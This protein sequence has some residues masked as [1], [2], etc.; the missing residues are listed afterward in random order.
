MPQENTSAGVSVR[1]IDLTGPT[2]IEPVGIPAGIIGT[3]A[4]G[5]AFVPMTLPTMPDFI[6]KFG[7]PTSIY[8]N[9]PLAANEWLRNAQA[10]TFLRVLG[11]GD[12]TQRTASGDN[13]GKVT[14]AGFVVGDEQPQASVS[15]ALSSNPYAVTTGAPGKT[16]FLGTF[17][18]QSTNSSVL[19]DAGL[20]AAGQPILRAVLMA[21]SG[22]VLALSSAT[23]NSSQP[24]TGSSSAI[25]RGTPSGS[26][27]VANSLQE[28]V[29]LL[30]G[31]N[32]AD[33][34]Y[35]NVITASF[36][37]TA[38]NYF[39]KVFN[40]DP[41]KVE[42]AGYVLYT[43]YDIHPSLAVVT[44]ALALTPSA[45][46]ITSDPVVPF[47]LEK[48]AF[49]VTNEQTWNSG[50]LYTPNFENF[51]DRFQ[52]AKTPWITSQKFGGNPQN[53]FQIVAL[54]DGEVPNTE[55]KISFENIQPSNSDVTNFGTF[56]L[57]VRDLNDNDNNKIV[58]EQWRGLS[59]DVDSPKF[60]G[61]VIGDTR[62]FFN[63]DATVGKQ[64]LTTVGNYPVKSRFIRLNL[65]DNLLNGETPETALPMGCRGFPHLMTSGSE[66]LATLVDATT[67]TV[68][69]TNRL[70][71]PPVPFRLNLTKGTSPNLSTDKALY[72]GVQFERQ[73]SAT[74][75]NNSY[76]PNDTIKSF[77]K[78]FANYHTDWLN[79]I[80]SSNEGAADTT[81]N[82]I[83][84]ADRFNFNAF[85]LENIR[86]VYNSTSGIADV[87]SLDSWAYVRS[88]SISTNS[89][90]LTRAL[91]VSD[92]LDPS[93]RA[94]AKFSVF[95]QGGFN[96]TRMFNAE[97]SQMTNNAIV[98]EMNNSDRGF[99]S[100]PTVSAYIKA[101]SVMEDTSEVDVQLLAIP[102]IRHRYV[103]DTAIRSTENRFDALYLF[104]IEERDTNNNLVTSD[105]Q[106]ISIDYTATDFSNRG[107]NSSF[108]A[109][110]F[111]DLMLQTQ[112]LRSFARTPPTVSVLGAFSLND[113]IGYPW[114]APAGFARGA[115]ASTTEPVV[116]LSKDNM[117]DLYSVRINPIVSFPGSTGP[118]VWGQKT[119]LARQSS[120]DRVNV[121]RLLISLRREVRSVA[122]RILFE[123]NREA[124]LTRFSQQVNPI[125]KKVQ[126]KRGIDNY[127]IVI[128]TSTTT[129]ADIENKTIRGKI[130]LIPT[131]TI[132]FLSIDFVLTNRGNFISG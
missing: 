11:I 25:V 15:G 75:P 19:T 37:I 71:Q 93:V 102:G 74:S 23:A 112:Y 106:T 126:D 24:S 16:Y 78:Y 82:G 1:E 57:L 39:G 47:T 72:W 125:F 113:A 97:T 130:F 62:T 12:G 41:L 4:K 8:K 46:A 98:E 26:V 99:S 114:N 58:L 67:W 100:G 132:E 5:P 70:V 120:L 55:F 115:L 33:T 69:T 50:T 45:S 116:R 111:P 22:V 54:S 42:N 118:V 88:G 101:L 85:S 122:N 84:D 110:Y 44:G 131:K 32:G 36:D 79:P 68:G 49:L 56:D 92:L 117:G 127:K 14:N 34:A 109:A 21:A 76:V 81:E 96:G 18:S 60:I 121:R 43:Y 89:T 40:K 77:T 10:V 90:A 64:K 128:D 7:P 51:E 124:T 105:T 83:V 29:M 35:S 73:E 17:M 103:T 123:N 94:V 38:P 27:N 104:D 61:N 119:V 30:N 65:S 80:T 3:S 63:F 6:V 13:Q 91:R 31:W 53:L 95:L 9:G 59:L 107:L 87:N 129:Q 2:S 20:S 28:F 108:A 86:V 66:P 52:A 48:A